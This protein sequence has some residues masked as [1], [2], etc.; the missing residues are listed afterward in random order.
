MKYLKIILKTV[1]N[2]FIFLV[3]FIPFYWM[4]LTSLKTLG[5][6]LKMPP[7]FF[8]LEP[9]FYNFVQVFIYA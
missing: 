8:V 9:Q 4:I 5:Q 7:S 3:F 2:I 6:T 1:I